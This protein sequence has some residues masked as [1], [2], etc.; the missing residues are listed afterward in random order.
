KGA[1][2]RR[3][4]CTSGRLQPVVA[5]IAQGSDFVSAAAGIGRRQLV[6]KIE[7]LVHGSAIGHVKTEELLLGFGEGPVQH[8]RIAAGLAQGHGLVGVPQAHHRA[9]PALRAHPGLNLAQ[10]RH[11]GL[12]LLQ[13]PGGALLFVIIAQNGIEHGYLLRSEA[14]TMKRARA[15]A[16][17]DRRGTGGGH[18]TGGPLLR[19]MVRVAPIEA[20]MMAAMPA[21]WK[22]ARVS[23]R[24]SRPKSSAK[25]DWPLI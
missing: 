22:A 21:T 11:A 19:A 18:A 25:A 17:T 6:R 15:D 23:C 12:V 16:K 13:G 10:P 8:H 20:A 1:A 24:M 5:E 2:R 7:R 9:Q 14:G 4:R 3:A